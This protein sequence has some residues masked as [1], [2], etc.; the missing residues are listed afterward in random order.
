MHNISSFFFPLLDLHGVTLKI[1]DPGDQLLYDQEG[2]HLAKEQPLQIKDEQGE[3]GHKQIKVEHKERE[4]LQ[5]KWEQ[6][7][8]DCQGIKAEQE[9][10]EH[11]QLKGEKEERECQQIKGEQNKLHISQSVLKQETDTMTGIL[12]NKEESHS[13]PELKGNKILSHESH[14]ADI[15][16][17]ENSGSKSQGK[18]TKNKKRKQTSRNKT[19]HQYS[20]KPKGCENAH[21]NKEMYFCEICDKRFS[22]NSLLTKHMEIHTSEEPCM[23]SVK[24]RTCTG[25]KVL[26]CDL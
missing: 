13:E 12:I 11:Q 21:K 5:I 22:C 25:K 24:M 2:I 4:H 7:E 14:N 1:E 8:Q 6:E 18:Q 26:S 3:Q 23:I 20:P 9:E 19:N 15:H 16:Y 10:R 17:H